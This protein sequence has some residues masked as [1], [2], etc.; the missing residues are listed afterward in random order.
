MSKPAARK[1]KTWHPEEIKAAIRMRGTT[2]SRLAQDN[3]L[4]ASA[5]RQALRRPSSPAGERVISAF[6]SIPLQELWPERYGPDGRRY[7]TRHVRVENKHER[8]DA[9]R[10]IVSVR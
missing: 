7:V 6:L 9:H 2:L 1:A 10:Q 4:E 3:D 5:C 8:D